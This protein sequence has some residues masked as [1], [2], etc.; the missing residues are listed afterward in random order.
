MCLVSC[1]LSICGSYSCAYGIPV[2]VLVL[3][4]VPVPVHVSI[5]MPMSM[6]MPVTK[7]VDMTYDQ[8]LRP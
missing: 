1:D 2:V 6:P 4:P 7:I 5:P 3:V 8:D